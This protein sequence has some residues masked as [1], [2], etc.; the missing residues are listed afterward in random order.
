MICVC[1]V[2][3]NFWLGITDSHMEGVWSF[4]SDGTSVKNSSSLG[5]TLFDWNGMATSEGNE[6]TQDCAYWWEAYGGGWWDAECTGG[7]GE[8]L[9]Y[10]C[11][12]GK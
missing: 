8:E 4:S 7:P 5:E 11:E 3:S 1:Q 12:K 9:N 10:V 2:S 6:Q